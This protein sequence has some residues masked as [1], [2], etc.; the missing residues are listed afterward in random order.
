[1]SHNHHHAY[2]PIADHGLIGD[3][4]TSALVSTD[5]T[6]DWFCCPRFDSPSV[7]ASLLDSTRG[8][9]FRVSPVDGEHTIK[10][11]YFPDSAVL[12]TRFMSEVFGEVLEPW[13]GP[14]TAQ[15]TLVAVDANAVQLPQPDPTIV[16][17]KPRRTARGTECEAAVQPVH[18]DGPTRGRRSVPR[19]WAAA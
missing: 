17:T 5:G 10:Q 14:Q 16:I 13:T 18:E 6:I 12:I 9:S 1:M 2:A 15:D 19:L 3:L 4:Q 8:G 11:M 7:F